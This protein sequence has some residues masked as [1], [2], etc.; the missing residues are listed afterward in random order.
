MPKTA[1]P[2]LSDHENLTLLAGQDTLVSE[3]RK[4]SE[5]EAC[6]I[7]VRGE[8]QG[9]RYEL[10][11]PT[12]RLGRETTSDIVLDD[13]K[14]SRR[15]AIIQTTGE[16]VT[17]VDGG[18]TN[19]TYIN[20]RRLPA[21]ASVILEKEDM[22]RIG[23]TVLKY[24]PR[25]ALEIRY[26]GLLEAKA[27]TDPLTKLYN[28]GYLLEALQAEFKRARALQAE[29]SVLFL[30][31][32]HFKRVNDTYGHDA[33]DRVL[34]ETSALLRNATSI[35]QGII[36]RFGG[37]EFVALLPGHTPSEARA[38]AEFVRKSLE[39]Q[40]IP[41]EGQTLFLTASIGVASLTETMNDAMELVKEA[42]KA[43]YRAKHGGRNRVCVA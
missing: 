30:D 19:G 12:M 18:S 5:C 11:K 24:L 40:P 16:I 17:W 10:S 1:T 2:S 28:K 34:I 35:R 9:R 8:P 37:E 15:Q 26:I 33:G 20:D 38:L 27:N 41:V 22:I 3:L 25:G 21:N 4:A 39:R 14:V 29:L 13:P 23:G 31:L 6:L 7:V 36:G 43:V 42:D 32:D